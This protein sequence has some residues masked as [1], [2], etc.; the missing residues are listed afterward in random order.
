MEKDFLGEPFWLDFG[1][2]DAHWAS[3]NISAL[4]GELDVLEEAKTVQDGTQT[5]K[6]QWLRG[7]WLF[8]SHNEASQSSLE[9]FDD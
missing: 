3:F 8:G 5:L 6:S 2:V 7:L 9:L 1:M 4:G